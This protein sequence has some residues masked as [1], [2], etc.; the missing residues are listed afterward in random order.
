MTKSKTRSEVEHLRGVIKE[1]KKQLKRTEKREHLYSDLESKKAELLL[2]EE[3]DARDVPS[4]GNCP[5]CAGVVETIGGSR[6]KISI[7]QNCG[8]RWTK[9]NM[10]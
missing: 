3:M 8:H 10:K 9:R 1:L 2:H 6:V 5:K 4:V 7:C